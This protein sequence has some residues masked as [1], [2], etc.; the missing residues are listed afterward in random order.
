MQKKQLHILADIKFWETVMDFVFRHK[1]KKSQILHKAISV[2]RLKKE[3]ETF[4]DKPYCKGPRPHFE[5]EMNLFFTVTEEE[6]DFLEHCAKV[7]GYF[8]K[9][10]FVRD[11]L[12][13]YMTNVD[14][15]GEEEYI[16]QIDTE[17]EDFFSEIRDFASMCSIRLK[18]FVYYIRSFTERIKDYYFQMKLLYIN[19]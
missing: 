19:I 9:S 1:L 5:Q 14:E 18:R 2:L 10:D 8:S 15:F 3:S 12:T 7:N 11:I 6:A 4:S 13:L 17:N 16:K